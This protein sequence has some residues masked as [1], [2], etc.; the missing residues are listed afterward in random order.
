MVGNAFAQAAHDLRGNN[1]RIAS[2]AHKSACGDSAT[3]IFAR[4][5]NW[6]FCQ[7]INN[8]SQ[9]K[10][11]VGARI[12]IGNGEHVQA[13]YLFLALAELGR[14]IS[15]LRASNAFAAAAMALMMSLDV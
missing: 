6:E 10:G 1:A 7:V 9:S 8:H 5:A 3:A 15:S 14:L 2:C 4:S 13:I 11:H 12:A